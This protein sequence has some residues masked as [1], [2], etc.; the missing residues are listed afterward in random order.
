MILIDN[1]G[2]TNPYINL[3]LEEFLVR[4]ANCE[5]NDYLLLY[6][7][8]PCVVVG[9]NQSIYKEVNF[10]FLRNDK[11]KLARRIS[12]GG[13]VYQDEGNLCFSFI[14]KF[15]NQKINNY[16][17]FNQ[18][19]VDALH[20]A[21][22]EAMMDERNNILAAQQKISGNAQFTNRKNIISHG[23]LLFNA[24]LTTLRACLKRNSFQVETKAVNSVP[25]GIANII[26]LTDKF[27][28]TGQLKQYLVSELT[29]GGVYA[30]SDED[31]LAIENLAD[32]KFKSFEWVYGRS[33][34]T[35]L[36]KQQVE[37]EIEN[38]IIEQISSSQHHLQF[39]IGEKYEYQSIKKA[40]EFTSNASQLLELI[41]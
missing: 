2:T 40:L 23:T 19:V 9:K 21:G 20:K 6:I 26:H 10:E 27:S 37:I 41:F 22:V 12:G 36:I 31:W 38:G 4:N 7:N 18:P 3:A 32:E 24:D 34:R 11:L 5:Q 33:P 15:S 14:S 39:L 29:S 8:E 13:T 35:K 30:F 28:S 25:S 1:R 17:H 16:R